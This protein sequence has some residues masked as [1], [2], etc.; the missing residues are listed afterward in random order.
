MKHTVTQA[1]VT[2]AIAAAIVVAVKVI[3]ARAAQQTWAMQD[4]GRFH[5]YL[6]GGLMPKCN[7]WVSEEC[8]RLYPSLLKR[9]PSPR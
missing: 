6:S 9:V 8:R 2:I 4:R 1:L 3:Q 5:G 7:P